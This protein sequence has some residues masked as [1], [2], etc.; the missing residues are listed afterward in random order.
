MQTKITRYYSFES[1]IEYDLIEN[2]EGPLFIYL[3]GYMQ[4]KY[5]MR[6]KMNLLMDLQGVHVF[7][8]APYPVYDSSRSRPVEK[9][10]RAWYLYDGVQ[11]QFIH[12]LEQTSK[13]LEQLIIGLRKEFGSDRL[14]LIGYSMGAY[15]AGYYMLSRPSLL[16]HC[17]NIN[18]R[19][20]TE[21]F[22]AEQLK[23]AS[24]ISVLALHGQGD[25]SVYPDPQS[26]EIDKLKQSGF[27]AEFITPDC[28]HD[29]QP[30][31]S[32]LSRKWL[33]SKGFVG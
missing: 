11:E 6:R 26:K 22:T 20:K 31:F 19:I 1:T 14:C 4:N 23:K 27:D 13:N 17:I 7:L 2:G 24:S 10:G 12:S 8:N 16:S 21:V 28:D 29:L 3:H 5:I 18:G 30:V 25:H 9:W 32:E 33:V 15:Q